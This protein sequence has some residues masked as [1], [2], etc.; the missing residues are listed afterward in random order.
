MPTNFSKASFWLHSSL[1][2]VPMNGFL[3][4]SLHRVSPM[5]DVFRLLLCCFL[6]VWPWANDFTSLN[7]NFLLCETELRTVLSL[8]SY[9]ERRDEIT[10]G[11]CSVWPKSTWYNWTIITILS[12]IF[13]IECLGTSLVAQ[14]LRIRLPMQG[15]WVQ[16]LVGE[17]PTCR[18]AAKPVRHNCWACALEPAS[19]NYWACV[20]QLLKPVRLEPTLHKKRSHCN[21]KPMCQNEE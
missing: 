1:R 9:C 2:W 11:K 4:L 18:G 8:Y 15:T 12:E 14:W 13:K 7:F 10:D 6:A 20:P 17:D 5:N 16:A 3:V 21:E 19:R